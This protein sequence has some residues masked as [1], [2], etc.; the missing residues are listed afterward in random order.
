[1]LHCTPPITEQK[2]QIRRPLQR[3]SV[4]DLLDRASVLKVTAF[5]HKGC[6]LEAVGLNVFRLGTQ[7][8]AL[9]ATGDQT[10][11]DKLRQV[12]TNP[13]KF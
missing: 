7:G 9:K 1:M 3:S 2:E 10:R 4:P 13:E 5:R 8:T 11:P 12:P 6:S